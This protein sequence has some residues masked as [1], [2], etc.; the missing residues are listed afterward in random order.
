M[1][2]IK[3]YGGPAILICFYIIYD[4]LHASMPKLSNCDTDV[5]PAKLEIFTL[6]ALTESVLT[7]PY[8]FH[9]YLKHFFFH[10]PP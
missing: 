7:L 4:Y 6:W 3:F 2:I 9:I 1:S 8:I 5:W 10:L